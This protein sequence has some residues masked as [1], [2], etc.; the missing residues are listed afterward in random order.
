MVPIT[1]RERHGTTLRKPWKGLEKACSESL[2]CQ[3][4]NSSAEEMGLGIHP[5]I[6]TE[7]EASAREVFDSLSVAG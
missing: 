2:F 7:F 6:F 4:I 5:E 3:I 1:A